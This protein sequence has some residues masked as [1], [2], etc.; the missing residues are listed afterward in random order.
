MTQYIRARFSR[1]TRLGVAILTTVILALMSGDRPAG[2]IATLPNAIDFLGTTAAAQYVTFGQATG[3]NGL[4]ATDFTVELW[5]KREGNSVQ[6]DA[7]VAQQAEVYQEQ[8]FHL[9]RRTRRGRFWPR[10][11][12]ST[13]SW[14]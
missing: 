1:A 4:N 3:A 9:S 11:S 2:Q 7:P 10:M 6:H 14:D 13:T 5:F 8:R 12:T